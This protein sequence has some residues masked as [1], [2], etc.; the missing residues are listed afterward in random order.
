[1]PEERNLEGK[2]L[3]LV[4][5]SSYLY[6]AYHAM[7]D[8]RGPGGEPT[9]ALYGIINMLRRMRKEVSAEYSACVFDAKGKTFRDDLYA[10]YKANR[11]SMPPDL[12][13]Q[14]EPI[15]AAV[16]ALGWPLL[17]VEGV[18][19]DDVIGT[20]AR[21]AE[22][23]GMK[24]VVSTGDK[25][26]AQLVTDRVTLVNTMTNEILDRDG[27]T[28][29]FGVPPERIIDYLALIG[30]TVDNVPG[31]EKCGPKTAVKW[32]T[33][34]DSLDGVI[35]HAGEIKGVVGDN[36][37]RALD[38]L[39]LGRKLVTVETACDLA[40]HLESIE[41]TLATDG[42]AR[43]L[44]RDIFARY[45]FK[46]WLREIDIALEQSGDA[47][48]SDGEPAPVV[49][50]GAVREYDTIQ[51][52]AQFDAWFAKIDAAALTAFDTE[53]T[54]LDPMVARLVGLS[55]SVEPGKAAYL[56]VAHRGP[57]L[58]EQLPLDDV[59]AR[60]KPWLESADRKKVGQHLK[61]DAQ[62]LANYGIELNGIE[63]DT[64]L[65][66]YVLE[67]HRTHDMDS[68]AL[69]HLG[70]KTIKYE[71]VAGKGAKQ[72][73]FDEVALAQAA[74][75]AAEDADVT[76]QLHHALYPQVA[77]EPGLERVYREIEMPVSIVLRKMERAGVLIDDAR[78][79]AQS[80]E[81]AT[82]LIE[83]EGQA[84]ELAGG[85]FN[86]GSPKQI[87]QIFFEKL[88]LPVVKK[89]PSGAPST[90]EEVLQKLAEDYPLPKLLL[91]HRGL[92]K[93]KST[94][95]DKLPRMVNPE[96]GRVHTNYAQAVAVTGRLASNDPN[97]Q[98]IP[99]RTAEG[100]RI[101]EAFIASP[102]HQIVS[103]DYSQ[104]ELRIMAHI[105]GDASLLRAFSNGED[106]HR[107]TAAEVFGVTPLEVTTDQRRIAKV[108]NFG[109]IYGM[110]SFGLASNLGI[111]RD[112]AKL[113]I[114][115]YFARYPGV[116]QYMEDTRAIAKEKGYVETVFG[117]RLWLPE[118]NG[119]NGPR[120]QA[121]ERA[122]INAPMQGTAADLIKLSMIAVDDWLTRDGLA[123]RMIMQVHDELVLEVP[124]AE[125]PRVREKL[126][127]MM[128][129]VAKLKVPLVAE[130][131]AG[132][133]WEEAH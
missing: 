99:V 97:L 114:D 4:D 14:V 57:D 98:N 44:L 108:I 96:T 102:G 35:E 87:G 122:A 32:L 48:A 47:D 78:L 21:E 19:A 120:R 1:M 56:P 63:H 84:Y 12:A 71:D 62:V 128:C 93:L 58:P 83:L 133:N 69:R 52:W 11:P 113:Y 37:R 27:V 38:F 95:T 65:E 9:G 54:S 74:E 131:G 94:Y 40:P 85:E 66:S 15:H 101:R 110:S 115:R 76:L 23:H 28:A 109:L 45:G 7:P 16:R 90:D 129:G 43:E 82:R 88:Q 126:P 18:E 24:V 41:A 116:A 112:A 125:L 117:R 3:L 61:Y 89:T 49:T 124:E 51:T 68:L 118:I 70:V 10:D 67:S 34:Y 59:L 86:L 105:S 77:R 111:T 75:Y 53:T 64:L 123:S 107:A 104:I 39:P 119:G 91:E 46:T 36:L 132:A 92:S 33:Q 6:R 55:F 60:L 25:D 127:E 5:G 2:T 20:L 30:D 79:Q 17:M 13:L 80:T 26:L 130:V 31:V 106:I 29:K 22:R 42:E 8:L 103:A 81:I 72:I 73:G 121:A 100:R 50:A